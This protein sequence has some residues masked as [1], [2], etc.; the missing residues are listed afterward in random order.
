MQHGYAHAMDGW[1]RWILVDGC[2]AMDG[3]H[4]IDRWMMDGWMDAMP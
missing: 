4:A 1:M 3:C 2:Y